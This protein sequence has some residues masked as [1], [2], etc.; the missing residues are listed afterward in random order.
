MK[1]RES[2][3]VQGPKRACSVTGI[4]QEYICLHSLQSEARVETAQK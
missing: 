3:A 4:Q 2:T 1:R